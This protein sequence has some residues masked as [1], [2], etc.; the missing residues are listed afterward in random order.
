M[1][2]GKNIIQDEKVAVIFIGIQASGKTTFYEKEFN[3]LVHI[4]LDDL[5]TRNKENQL[6]HE[7]VEKGISF[8]ADNTNPTKADREKY[9]LAAKEYG[10]KIKGYYFRSSIRESVERNSFREGKAK[11]P[12]C[13][14]AST[15]NR[16]ELP[17]Y[18]E[19]F[20]ELYYVYIANNDFSVQDWDEDKL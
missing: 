20:D 2:F 13:A 14:I 7:C 6:L 1:D 10:Y 8:V 11:V 19:G 12:N 5:H 18:T 3:K 16:L 4:N 15:H 9:I 17:E